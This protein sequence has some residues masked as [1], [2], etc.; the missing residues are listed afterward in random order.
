VGEIVTPTICVEPE[1]KATLVVLSFTGS[2]FSG[3]EE[4]DA[5]FRAKVPANPFTLVRL[6]LALP[7]FP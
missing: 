1:V 6:I 7:V 3:P 4:T 5:L 2:R